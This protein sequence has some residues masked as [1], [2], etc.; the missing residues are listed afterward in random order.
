M[1]FGSAVKEA[2]PNVLGTAAA[3]SM[4]LLSSTVIDPITANGMCLRK[5]CRDE[6]VQS[7]TF[8]GVL[9]G[10][11]DLNGPREVSL[12]VVESMAEINSR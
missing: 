6:L 5:C 11:G 10:H 2:K 4:M 7:G 3:R 8:P 1:S 12:R 9:G